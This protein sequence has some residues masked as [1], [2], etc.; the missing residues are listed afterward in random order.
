M[1][2][3]R[4]G[5]APG[6]V[7]LLPAWLPAGYVQRWA[8]VAASSITAN[9]VTGGRDV[10][11][12][13]Y[14]RGFDALTVTTRTVADPR[15]ATTIDPVEPDTSWADLVHRDVRLTSG[16]FAGVTA[17]VVVAPYITAPHLYAV[18]DDVLLTVTG[19]ATAEELIAIAESLR[20]LPTG[21]R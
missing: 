17:R 20:P 12:L 13:Q 9:G 3:A 14:A 18:K 10:V 15:A 5:S 2:L 11:A 7:T 1:P 16:A 19:G 8:A 6:R 21:S 4:I